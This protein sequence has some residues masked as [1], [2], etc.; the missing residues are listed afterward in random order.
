MLQWIRD[1]IVAASV[2]AVGVFG[3]ILMWYT[4]LLLIS[5]YLKATASTVA[6]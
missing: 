2:V 3:G 6:G 4:F 1:F 5:E